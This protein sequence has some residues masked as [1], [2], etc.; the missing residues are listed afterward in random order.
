[1]DGVKILRPSLDDI[2]KNTVLRG[3]LAGSQRRLGAIAARSQAETSPARP[4]LGVPC[5]LQHLPL[6]SARWPSR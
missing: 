3:V 4:N 5:N 1:M 6:G 2:D